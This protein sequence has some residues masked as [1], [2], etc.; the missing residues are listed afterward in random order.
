MEIGEYVG[1][2]GDSKIA[3][4]PFIRGIFAFADSLILGTRCL[5]H[6]ASFYEEE[7]VQES[8]A[9]KMLNK[10]FRDKAESILMVLTTVIA[11]VFWVGIFI[12]M[13]YF[14]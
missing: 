4:V 10:V 1:I 3:K 12:V 13:P 6:S 9:D 2:T 11:V 5:N 8:A 14:N 7:D